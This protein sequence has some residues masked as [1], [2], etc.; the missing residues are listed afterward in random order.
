MY[1]SR[2]YALKLPVL[3]SL[4]LGRDPARLCFTCPLRCNDGGSMRMSISAEKLTQETG[5]L[6]VGCYTQV[7]MASFA[8]RLRNGTS[9]GTSVFRPVE[10]TCLSLRP[11]NSAHLSHSFGT[12]RESNTIPNLLVHSFKPVNRPLVFRIRVAHSPY[13]AQRN[14][15]WQDSNHKLQPAVNIG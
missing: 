2:G 6:M 12:S 1:S 5:Y 10:T 8:R 15:S 13:H 3:L 9:G 11:I 14:T 4:I 7:Y